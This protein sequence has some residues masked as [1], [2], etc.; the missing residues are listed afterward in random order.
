MRYCSG[1]RLVRSLELGTVLKTLE[2]LLFSFEFVLHLYSFYIKGDRFVRHDYLLYLGTDVRRIRHDCRKSGIP[3]VKR[4]RL[5]HV[6]EY[7]GVYIFGGVYV[8]RLP[9]S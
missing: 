8:Q 7:G 1:P 6:R 4:R 2:R 3:D 5:D 9:Y